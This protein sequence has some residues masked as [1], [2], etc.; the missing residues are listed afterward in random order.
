M[1]A[2]AEGYAPVQ[3]LL[4]EDSL[5]NF[6]LAREDFRNVNTSVHLHV[7][8]DGI[9]AMA[10]LRHKGNH[11]DA[12]RPDLI[13]LLVNLPKVDG[14]E[15]L[16]LFNEGA[17]LKTIRTVVLTTSAAGADIVKSYQ[18]RGCCNSR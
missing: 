18:R 2:I 9:E 17:A 12:P 6:R 10:F 16:A 15:V 14:C 7:A 8:R 1:T 4:I 5:T 13:L 11:R 3:R